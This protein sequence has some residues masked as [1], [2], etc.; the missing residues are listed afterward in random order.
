[1]FMC[2]CQS[3]KTGNELVQAGTVMNAVTEARGVAQV[4]QSDQSAL[5]SSLIDTS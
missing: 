5:L 1:M 3:C 4:D 2:I